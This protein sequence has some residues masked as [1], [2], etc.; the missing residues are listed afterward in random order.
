VSPS[1][2]TLQTNVG[3]QSEQG[4]G[5]ILTPDG[6]IMT[7]NHIVAAVV[8]G[9]PEPVTTVVRFNDGRTAPFAVVAA[10]PMSDIAVARAQGI[11]GLAPISIGSSAG[12][13][14][15]QPAVAVGSPLG[16]DDTVTAGVISALDRPVFTATD[17]NQFAAVDAIQTDAALNPGNSGGSVTLAQ[18]RA[19]GVS[20][21]SSKRALTLTQSVAMRALAR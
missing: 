13:R 12:L 8:D 15:G 2:V 17:G 1:V 19:C 11:S 4:S 9:P 18:C 7:N 16:L 10:D 20:R 21:R 6:L 5:I 3:S 14:V